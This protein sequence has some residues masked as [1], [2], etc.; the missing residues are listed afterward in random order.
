[1]KLKYRW[2]DYDLKRPPSQVC[3]FSSVTPRKWTMYYGWQNT[4]VEKHPSCKKK[5]IHFPTFGRSFMTGVLFAD[6]SERLSSTW[7][8]IWRCTVKC[9]RSAHGSE[10]LGLRAIDWGARVPL[11][12]LNC[13]KGF[14]LGAFRQFGARIGKLYYS[15]QCW[16]LRVRGPEHSHRLCILFIVS[17]S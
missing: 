17:F 8:D 14:F 15:Y 12:S 1:M 4:S 9:N 11:Q 2:P 3:A 16:I 5:K 6:C 10:Q 13:C 7:V